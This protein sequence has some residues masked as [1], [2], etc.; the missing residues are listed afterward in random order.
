MTTSAAS[1]PASAAALVSSIEWRVSLVPVPQTISRLVADLVDDRAQQADV[2]VV[3]EGRRLAGRAGDDQPVRAVLDQVSARALRAAA[4]STAPSSSKGVTIAVST[5][6]QLGHRASAY[7]PQSSFSRPTVKRS[8][9]VADPAHR[10]Q[11]ARA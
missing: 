2:L 9:S 7:P 10:E 1:A 5:S 3:V 6:S 8:G 11:H 4:S